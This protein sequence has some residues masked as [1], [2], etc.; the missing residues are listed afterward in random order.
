MLRYAILYWA[1]LSYAALCYAMLLY[2]MLGYAALCCAMLRY[3]CY[4]ML[5]CAMLCYAALCYFMLC[6]ASF[7]GGGEEKRP[8]HHCWRMRVV[9]T[10]TWDFVHVCTLS[11]YTLVIS[12]N[13][14][15]HDYECLSVLLQPRNRIRDLE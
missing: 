15:A 6:L 12:R 1:M 10:K 11:A 2:A 3:I 14:S 13:I 7:P 4:A 5:C 9:P 8:G